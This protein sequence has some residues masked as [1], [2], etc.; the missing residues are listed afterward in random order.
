MDGYP[1]AHAVRH[2]QLFLQK[3]PGGGR[4]VRRGQAE[5]PAGAGRA[6]GCSGQLSLCRPGDS[7]QAGI[8]EQQFGQGQPGAPGRDAA[9]AGREHQGGIQRKG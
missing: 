4:G 5:G 7:G 2:R 1:Q 6:N 8:G 9:Q 3:L